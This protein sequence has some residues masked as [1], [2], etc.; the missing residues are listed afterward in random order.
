MTVFSLEHG[1]LAYH[2]DFVLYGGAVVLLVAFL[3]LMVPPGHRPQSAVLALAGL[4]GWSALEY[5][6]HRFVLH[7]LQPFRGWHTQHHE[8]PTA[9]ICTPTI[10][11][12]ALFA[13]LVFLPAMALGGVAR[14]CALMVGILSGYLAFAITHH[15]THHWRADHAWLRGR[16][17]WHAQHHRRAA[18]L[19][20]CYGVTSGIWDHVFGSAARNPPSEGDET[21]PASTR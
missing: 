6:L 20:G 2:A 5:A 18:G 12:A 15:A 19:P 16:K 1:K 3:A 9:L 17:R 13:V 11:T 8:R 4:V 14:A 7:G 10:L 21:C